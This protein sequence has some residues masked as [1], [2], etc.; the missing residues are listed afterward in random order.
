MTL[1]NGNQFTKM[2]H[3][4]LDE[5]IQGGG[6]VKEILQN[7]AVIFCKIDY[8]STLFNFIKFSNKQYILITHNS[9]YP[10]DMFRFNTRPS[11]I[12]KWF[13]QN[14]SVDHPDLINIPIGLENEVRNPPA[15]PIVD[16]HW[17]YEN[18]RSFESKDK[19]QD[20]V[21]CNWNPKTNASRNHIINGLLNNGI[22]VNIEKERL[23]H[24]EYC[25]KAS[26]Y[27]YIICP[28]GNGISTHRFWE[29]LYFGSIPIVINH[30]IYRDYNLPIIKLSKWGD[31][32]NEKLSNFNEYLFNRNQLDFNYWK[33]IIMEEFIKL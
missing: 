16:Y 15:I 8:I 33:N 24:K 12:K 23:S 31:L 26:N 29:T 4:Y 28:E 3:Y 9:D 6:L 22:K 10:V 20:A 25:N 30:R 7:N 18:I 2:A 11:C 32:T 14:V 21:Y 5:H 13:G 27:K 1:I 19:I 17:F